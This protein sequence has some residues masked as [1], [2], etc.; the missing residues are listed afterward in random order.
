MM[1]FFTGLLAGIILGV[2]GLVALGLSM[3]N[4]K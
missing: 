3:N 4:K 2:M 1:E